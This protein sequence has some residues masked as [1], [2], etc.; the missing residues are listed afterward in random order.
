MC[1][2]HKQRQG[3]QIR[4]VIY[5]L[6]LPRSMIMAIEQITCNQLHWLKLLP[7]SYIFLLR[8]AEKAGIFYSADKCFETGADPGN[9][10]DKQIVKVCTPCM[11]GGILL[12]D[13]ARDFGME[14]ESLRHHE[15]FEISARADKK[16]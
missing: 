10:F 2:L 6:A 12:R 14:F 13:P 4:V 8:Q 5:H 3:L 9:I 15:I 11:F 16:L 1:L 7:A